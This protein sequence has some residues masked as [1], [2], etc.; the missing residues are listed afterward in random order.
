MR[1]EGRDNCCMYNVSHSASVGSRY[2]R[3]SWL[4]LG[5]AAVRR[6]GCAARA[7]TALASCNAHL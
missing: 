5:Q 1:F 6:P 7:G 3:G 4:G 2:W